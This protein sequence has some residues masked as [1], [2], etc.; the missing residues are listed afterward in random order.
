MKAMPD[1]KSDTQQYID[2]PK[3]P[4][5]KWLQTLLGAG[6]GAVFGALFG[7]FHTKYFGTAAAEA[8]KVISDCTVNASIVMAAL[9]NVRGS[10]LES[11]YEL[12]LKNTKLQNEIIDLKRA[13]SHAENVTHEKAGDSEIVR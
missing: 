1:K 11:D 2:Q 6:G 7:K 8:K 13:A 10:W 12:A 3:K 9:E 5:N 4:M